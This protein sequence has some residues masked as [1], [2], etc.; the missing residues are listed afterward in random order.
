MPSSATIRKLAFWAFWI[1]FVIWT[2]LL[3]EP[4]PVP[5]KVRKLLSL[6]EYLQFILAKSLHASGYAFL[7]FTLG[8]WVPHRRPPLTLAFALLMAHG[9][10]TEVIQTMVPN[11]SGMVRDVLIDWFGVSCGVLVGRRFWRPLWKAPPSQ[12][13][14]A[15]I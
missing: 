5:E 1:A 12:T 13:T 7:A 8:I 10:S 9:V 15:Q 11:R 6:Y 2:W 14:P 3:I 4:N